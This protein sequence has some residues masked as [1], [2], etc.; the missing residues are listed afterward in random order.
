MKKILF[1]LCLL[2]IGCF[3]EV[4]SQGLSFE[5]TS[6]DDCWYLSNSYGLS[7]GRFQ[8]FSFSSM[9]RLSADYRI[10]ENPRLLSMDSFGYALTHWLKPV[11]GVMYASGG[12]LRPTTGLQAMLVGK[13]LMAMANQTFAFR[14]PCDWLA[15]A[16]LQYSTSFPNDYRSFARLQSLSIYHPDE[17]CVSLVRFR[18]GMGHKR[19]EWGLADDLTLVGKELIRYNRLGVFLQFKFF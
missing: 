8:K 16:M 1:V 2:L 13:H 10:E 12:K 15:I 4:R 9:N 18:L 5:L 19:F 14:G 7:F 11:A 3:T 17:H 6:L